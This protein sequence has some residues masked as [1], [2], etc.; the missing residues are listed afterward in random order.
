[1]W[2]TYHFSNLGQLGTLQPPVF[3]EVLVENKVFN[4]S[5]KALRVGIH[6][7]RF[8]LYNSHGLTRS[9]DQLK[10]T[11]MDKFISIHSIFQA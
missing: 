4:F 11:G 10:H 6:L 7:E 9:R 2:Y 1:M 8:L 3:L 5:K